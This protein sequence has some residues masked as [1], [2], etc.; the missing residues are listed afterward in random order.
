MNVLLIFRQVL[1]YVFDVESRELEKDMHYYQSCLEAI[2]QVKDH[3]GQWF[4]NFSDARTTSNNLVVRKAQIIDLYRDSRTTSA[5][6]AD[7]LWYAEQT[8][9]ITALM[10]HFVYTKFVI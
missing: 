9:G 8:L 2:L 5:S 4:P 7:H 10:C 6:Y 1:I 3:L